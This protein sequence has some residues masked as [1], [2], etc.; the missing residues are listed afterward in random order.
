MKG[1]YMD[2]SARRRFKRARDAAKLRPLT[3]HHLRH[4]FGSLA[5]NA[6]SIV[7]VQTWMGHADVKTT[8][9]Y[10]H[11]KSQGDAAKRLSAVFSASGPQASDVLVPDIAFRADATD[12]DE[13]LPWSAFRRNR[14]EPR[15]RSRGLPCRRSWVRVP[16]SALEVPAKPQALSSGEATRQASW[17]RRGMDSCLA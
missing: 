16:S 6:G 15:G 7:D 5:I 9:R 14:K 12:D 1:G 10:L 11:Y 4:C 13:P 3:F 2:A 17:S 8:M